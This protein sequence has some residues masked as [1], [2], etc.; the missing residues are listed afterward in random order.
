MK[1]FFKKTEGFT[2]V[3]LIVVI[4]ILGILAGVGT[5][6]YSG[7]MKKANMAADEVLLNSLNTAF[8]AACIENGD[9]VN[10]LDVVP[11]V[12]WNGK[13]VVGVSLHNEDFLA[14]Y[15]EDAEFKVITALKFENGKFVGLVD[16]VEF[17][18]N[19]HKVVVSQGDVDAYMASN[20]GS[21]DSDS[22]LT[23]VGNVSDMA[24]G[25]D[26]A[27]FLGMYE[28][29]AYLSAAAAAL[30]WT[31]DEYDAKF[32]AMLEEAGEAWL[33]KNPGGDVE[34]YKETLGSQ[35]VANNTILVAAKGAQSTGSGIIDLLTKDAGVSAKESIKTSMQNDPA[36]GLSQAALAYGLYSSY[37]LEKDPEGFDP[38]APMDFSAVMNTMTEDGFQ[39]YLTEGNGQ[40]DLNG[41]L[42]ALNTVNNNTGTGGIGTDILMNGF[43]NQELSDLLKEIMGK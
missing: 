11:T 24:S 37:M 26:N 20:W 42:A 39:E 18:Y 34:A 1:K 13:S 28:N 15:D 14:Y 2:L 33:E 30:G 27:V 35:M 16:G 5:V 7:Y 40:K 6:G 21:V 25:I 4:A 19:G 9:D 36:A 38:D 3:E 32:T 8:A 43:N 23:L 17:S 12:S 22:I 41:Y 10:N 31:A 29:P